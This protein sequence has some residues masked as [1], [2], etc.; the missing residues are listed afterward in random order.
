[1]NRMT[2]RTFLGGLSS[3]SAAS[4]LP[5]SVWAKRSPNETPNLAAVGV[6]GKGWVDSNGAAKHGNIVAFC[7]VE[8]SKGRKRGGVASAAGK[9]PK[10]RRYTDWRVMLEKEKNLDGITVST[11]DHMHAAVTMTALQQGIGCYTQK[12]LTRTIHESRKVAEAAAR[13]GVATQMGNQNHSGTTYRTLVDLVKKGMIGK[14]KRAHAWSNRPIWPQ[15]IKRPS[16]TATPPDSLQWDLWLGVAPER[17]FAP[18]I[19]H[20]FKWRGWYDFGTGALGDMGCHIIDPIYWALDLTAP[21]TVL[22][23]GPEPTRETFPKAERIHYEFPGTDRTTD[24]T[25]KVTWH[26][27]GNLPDPAECDLPARTKLPA[28]GIILV[29]EKGVIVCPHGTGP[30]PR[31]YP[32]KD[33]KGIDFQVLPTTDH[34]Q[35][36][37]DAIRGKGKP[38]SSF[39]YAGPLCETVLLGC[40]ASRVPGVKLE[41]DARAL[42]FANSKA[43]DNLLHREYR[44][45]WEVAGL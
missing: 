9:W 21:N 44:K 22:Y 31:L 36:W 43:A 8:G 42:R 34:Y 39:D 2:R 1:M 25:I 27:G 5:G 30:L 10:A 4:L 13:S 24:R 7:D 38:T 35:Q 18:G 3:A 26:D 40:V 14:V 45:G 16:A 32:E 23:E 41:W 12:P 11:P 28:N 29:G 37:V 20:P 19:Y 17:P 33:F 15:G 6:G